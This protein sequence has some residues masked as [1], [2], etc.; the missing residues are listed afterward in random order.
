MKGK[1]IFENFFYFCEENKFNILVL[2]FS[3]FNCTEKIV[4]L[5]QKSEKQ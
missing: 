4:L 3:F 5:I 2:A 1:F